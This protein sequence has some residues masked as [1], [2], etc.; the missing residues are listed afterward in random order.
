VHKH[1]PLGLPEQQLCLQHLKPSFPLALT[2]QPM[3]TKQQATM[4]TLLG[5]LLGFG[6]MQMGNALQGTLL[7]IRG[8]IE[9]FFTSSRNLPQRPATLSRVSAKWSSKSPRTSPDAYPVHLVLAEE[10]AAEPSAR[11]LAPR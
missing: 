2:Y 11:E 6:L 4:A 1:K 10:A 5:L 3:Q 8:G 7:S 9:G